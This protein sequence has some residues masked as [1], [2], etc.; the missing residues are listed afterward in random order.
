MTVKM[1]ELDACASYNDTPEVPSASEL[2]GGRALDQLLCS[3]ELAKSVEELRAREAEIAQRAA[4][5]TQGERLR[6][7]T[8]LA[9]DILSGVGV[10]LPTAA[11]DDPADLF[12]AV[13]SLPVAGKTASARRKARE[14]ARV[15]MLSDEGGLH[16]P[17]CAEDLRELWEQAMCGEPRWSTDYPSSAFR[18]SAV[19]LRG[20]W[21]E[22]VVLHRCMDPDEVPAWL[23]RLVALL[24]DERF[25]PEVRAACGLG[26]QDWIHPFTDGNGHTGR[27]L[28]L[29]RLDGFYSQ[30]TLVCLAYELVANR[31][32]TLQQFKQLRERKADAIGFCLGMLVQ[33]GDA[34]KRA[35]DMLP[36]A[37][38]SSL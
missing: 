36:S 31:A 17:K 15:A 19:V 38:R 26:L 11:Y 20:P 6:V 22:R 18:T 23:D 10:V 14:V 8:E 1:S 4:K 5:A 30:P 3:Q 34:Q 33:V 29:A 32:V 25:T 35:L 7:H 2:F 12:E 24:S 9:A 16:V 21:P 37:S 27:L 28:M 13:A